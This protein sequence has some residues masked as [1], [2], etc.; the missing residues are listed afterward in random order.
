MVKDAMNKELTQ[1]INKN[2]FEQIDS[3][4]LRPQQLQHVV[5]TRWVI[6]Q[7]P[8]NSGTKDIKCR[9]CGQ[10]FSQFI[11]DTDTQTLAATPSSMAM[12][13]LLTIAII[14]QFTVFTIDVASAFLNTPID[15]EVLVQPPKEYYHKNPHILWKMTKALYT[16][17]TSPKISQEHLSTILQQLGLTR[18]KSDTCVFANRQ[19]TIHVMLY[20]DDLLVVGG[21]T[22]APQFLQQFQQH[23][24]LKH[25]SQLTTTT[26]LEFLGKTVELQH[27]G[28]IQLSFA[29]Q[30][31]HKILKTYNMD[32]CN[33]STT[34]GNRKPLIAAQPLDEEQHSMFSTD[35]IPST[36]NF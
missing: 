32:K 4:T 26:P 29:P 14:K 9:F 28:T 21:S 17:H 35:Y 22:S 8:T 12:R 27:D 19:S 1:L 10:G 31:H 13:L 2:S 30:Y 3:R 16:L 5:A 24:E 20:V 25:T 18:L 11:H 34:P 6:T 33:P 23:L 7:R 36:H 15:K